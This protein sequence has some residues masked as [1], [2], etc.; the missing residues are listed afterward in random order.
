MPKKLDPHAKPFQPIEKAFVREVLADTPTAGTAPR[1]RTE[2][3]RVVQLPRSSESA[4]APEHHEEPAP[5]VASLPDRLTRVLKAKV[6]TSEH[7]ELTRLVNELSLELETPVS[8]THVIRA[9]ITIL[10]HAEPELQRRA[11]L[12]GPLRRPPNDDLTAIAAFEFRLAKLLSAALRESKPL[13]E[14]P[15]E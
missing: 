14:L 2:E 15:R 4:P 10:R 11:K 8:T 12:N 13:R 6:S 5:R 7:V 1:S 9:L 3:S